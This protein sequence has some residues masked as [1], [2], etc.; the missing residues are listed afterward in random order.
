MACS[1]PVST[2]HRLLVATAFLLLAWGLP[3]ASQAPA[4]P[5]SAPFFDAS[6]LSEPASLNSDW[7][8]QPG[9]DPS[10][11]RPDFDD[12]LWTP[13]DLAR[14]L[15]TYFP[16]NRPLIVWYRLHVKVNADEAGLALRQGSVARASEVY[17]NGQPFTAEGQID[18]PVPYTWNAVVLRR[19]PDSMLRSGSLVIAIRVRISPTEWVYQDPGLSQGNLGLGQYDTF[20]RFDWLDIIGQ[21]AMGWLDHLS[22]IALGVVAL[23]LFA[24]QRRQT[25]Y[26]WIAAL[27]ALTLVECTEPFV[28]LFR[29]IPLRWEILTDALR[30]LTPYLWTSLYFAFIGKRIGW[31]WRFFLIFAGVCNAF[32]GIQPFFLV[33]PLYILFFSNLPFIVLLSLVVP[34]MLAVH[35]RR[36]NRE[37]GI[38]LIPAVLFSLY[39]YAEIGFETLFQFPGE[40]DT[41][42]RGLNL[43]DRFPAGPFAVSLDHISGILST[44]ALAI[45]MLLRSTSM[46]RRQAILESELAAAQQVQQVLLPEQIE[47]VPGFQVETVYEPAQQV[48][49]DFFQILPAES[50]GLLVF[51]GDVAGKGL[52]AAMLVSVL[53]GA[54]RSAA[55]YTEDPAE[56]LGNLNERLVG[57]GGGS[58]STA[59]VAHIAANGQATI[60]NAGHLSPYLDGRE[61]ELPGDLPLGVIS[62][63]SYKTSQFYLPPGSRLTFYS[64]GVVEAQNTKGELFGFDRAKAIST[65]P[66]SEIVRSAQLFGQE[67]DITVVTIE[68]EEAIASA[69]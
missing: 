46:S 12:A 37:A 17:L 20:Y 31:G 21:N 8:M 29:N 64:D 65:R 44:L 13:V 63:T 47:S 51:V 28:S 7:R 45:I 42:L 66:A 26:L 11:S 32:S 4:I 19:V 69:A 16:A 36:G 27:A 61:V 22:T 57:R 35:W 18:P 56:L 68:R 5:A 58:F 41:A 14:D 33:L 1:K 23:A 67:D 2:L 39:I 54:I 53:V 3:A 34:I 59:L 55:Q 52:P 43:I 9:D 50:G 6:H 62:G 60:A 49:G 25:E 40:R 38:L 24:S 48:G 10:W 15:K 30:V